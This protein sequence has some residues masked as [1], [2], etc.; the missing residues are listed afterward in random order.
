MSPSDAETPKLKRTSWPVTLASQDLCV[1]PNPID[2][3][4]TPNVTGTPTAVAFGQ[5]F[6]SNENCY[7][8]YPS[9]FAYGTIGTSTWDS[10]LPGGI[11]TLPSTQLQSFR[12]PNPGL[13]TAAAYSFNFAD[14]PPNHVPILAYE[15]NAYC[16]NNA[17]DS[18]G[19]PFCQTIVENQYAP[20]LVYPTQ[21]YALNPA[22][23]SC[24]FDYAGLYDPPTALGTAGYLVGPTTNNGGG[25]GAAP[26]TSAAPGNSGHPVTPPATTISFTQPVTSPTGSS[27]NSGSG[28]NT[29]SGSGTGSSDPSGGDS[30]TGGTG[31]GSSG[32]GGN[33]GSGT[34]SSG[35]AGSGNSGTGNGGTG[36]S[37]TG[38]GNTGT[39]NTGT[40]DA[41]SGSG[42][43]SNS[44][45]PASGDSGTGS[46]GNTGSGNSGSG[47]GNGGTGNTG[48]G[49][50][51]GSNSGSGGAPALQDT[52]PSDGSGSGSGTGAVLTLGNGVGSNAGTVTASANGNGGIVV[53]GQTISQ[54]GA[55]ATVSGNII[56]VAQGGSI[57]VNPNGIAPATVA[58]SQL[59]GS[60]S[61]FG[62]DAA[63]TS[64]PTAVL[65]LGGEVVT[66]TAGSNGGVV[67]DGTSLPAGVVAT[68]DGQ[69]VSVAPGGSAVVVAENGQT[70]TIPLIAPSAS[71]PQVAVLTLGDGE[72]VTATSI[73]GPNGT[74]I[75]VIGGTTLT[76]GGPALTTDGVV[77]SAGSGGLV[78]SGVGSGSGSQVA[79]A[80]FT[81]GSSTFTAYES[82]NGQG[83]TVVVI[84][85]QTLTVGGSPITLPDG[86]VVS[87]GTSGLI[88]VGGGNISSVPYSGIP[89]KTT[90]S[91]HLSSMTVLS[92]SGSAGTATAGATH[93]SKK[94]E[95]ERVQVGL[96]SVLMTCFVA[97]LGVT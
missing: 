40:G 38:S 33:T 80:I 61:G 68:V 12:G 81:I 6:T 10:S 57:V 17:I 71:V 76:G 1:Y 14:L 90:S 55:A 42:T 88:M 48:S 50:D 52:D 3:T 95:V 16:A 21:F 91:A 41:G 69:T 73:T 5:T 89:A 85:S 60:G 44:G 24:N 27:G 84:G 26:T 9:I 28:G 65:T 93:T 59:G 18:V 83:A 37:G 20:N 35:N 54:G 25:G 92:P 56:S 70:R 31:S 62:A 74:P 19:N 45:D 39:G 49:T 75:I 86:E 72:V 63:V 30:G 53:A 34:G 7:L 94:N 79:G 32:S 87:A 36:N 51:S 64:P 22:W 46:S 96:A 78:M 47:S 4:A 82:I 77:L 43:G 66:A 58:V 8:I 15:G 97:L 13:R 29:G 2:I 11:L 23:S 67:I